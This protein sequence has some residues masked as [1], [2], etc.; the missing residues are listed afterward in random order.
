MRKAKTAWKDT[1][2]GRQ[3][4]LIARAE[5]QAKANETGYD[6]GIEAND[7]FKS[8]HVFMLPTKANRFGHE[9]RCEVVMCDFL[10]RCKPGHGPRG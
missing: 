7:L 1:P 5:A 4:Y 8:W 6:Y 2:A 10:D 3:A 9:A